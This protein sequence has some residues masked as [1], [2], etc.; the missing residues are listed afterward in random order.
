VSCL[1]LGF[2]SCPSPSGLGRCRVGSYSRSVSDERSEFVG[3]LN[4]DL[5]FRDFL[6]ISGLCAS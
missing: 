5:L 3:F 6:V 1:L 4:W 2:V